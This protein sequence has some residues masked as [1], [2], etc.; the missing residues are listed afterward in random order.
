MKAAE[1]SSSPDASE[2][3]PED[4]SENED[5]VTSREDVFEHGS[6]RR[7]CLA[8]KER[9]CQINLVRNHSASALQPI[10]LS[11]STLL[12]NA[13]DLVSFYCAY[14]ALDRTS[15]YLY[16]L[17]TSAYQLAKTPV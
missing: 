17:P 4:A 14:P 16:C 8:H 2:N 6:R 7:V 10:S 3:A 15:C 9:K 12:M 1:R 11:W 13:L 5:A